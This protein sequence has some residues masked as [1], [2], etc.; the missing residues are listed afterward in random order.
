MERVE[1]DSTA[2]LGLSPAERTGGK[3]VWETKEQQSRK[4]PEQL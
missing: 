2:M 3:G 1:G 4:Q